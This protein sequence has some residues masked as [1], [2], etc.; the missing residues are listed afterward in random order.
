MQQTGYNRTK[1]VRC[2]HATHGCPQ[3]I[4]GCPLCPGWL[5]TIDRQKFTISTDRGGPITGGDNIYLQDH[6]G[7]YLSAEIKPRNGP[8]KDMSRYVKPWADLL[9][10]HSQKSAAQSFTVEQRK[11]SAVSPQNV[12]TVV[13]YGEC[14]KDTKPTE[15]TLLGD[16]WLTKSKAKTTAG[17]RRRRAS[18]FRRGG[19]SALDSAK[20][21]MQTAKEGIKTAAIQKLI[22]YLPAYARPTGKHYLLLHMQVTVVCRWGH[23]QR[24]HA[25]PTRHHW[26]SQAGV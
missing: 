17:T 19:V 6:R 25:Q 11:F 13:R 15:Q 14:I 12:K 23:P 20:E 26:S 1:W 4:S 18:M 8:G 3:N 7:N 9:A 22:G 10:S 24:Y 2:K 5:K 21:H 16:S